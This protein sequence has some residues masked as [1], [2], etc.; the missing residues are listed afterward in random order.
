MGYFRARCGRWSGLG[1]ISPPAER[2]KLTICAG[3]QTEAQ[4][5]RDGRLYDEART[6]QVSDEMTSLSSKFKCFAVKKLQAI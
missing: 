6:T 5:M 3:R 4:G 1:A 2:S